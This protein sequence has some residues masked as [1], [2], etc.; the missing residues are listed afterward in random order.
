MKYALMVR[1]DDLSKKTAL[2]IK[3]SLQNFLFMMKKSRS[4]YFNWRRWNYFRS[5][6]SIF[7]CW[8]LF[9][10]YTYRNF[11]ILSDYQIDEVDQ[12]IKDV[13]SRQFKTMKRYMLEIKINKKDSFQ[14]YY[15]LNELR[16]DQGLQAQVIH[17]YIGNVLLEVFR[18]NG[19][20]VSTL[21]DRLLIINL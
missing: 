9:C 1:N 10:R 12:F 4:C 8:L 2:K 15:A 5:C 17:V 3:E 11:R 20:C 13:T 14:T 21:L 19:L 7:K 16:L 18:G 6:T